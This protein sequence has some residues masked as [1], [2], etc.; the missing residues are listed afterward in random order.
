MSNFTVSDLYYIRA[1][2]YKQVEA[3]SNLDLDDSDPEVQQVESLLDKIE[4][5]LFGEIEQGT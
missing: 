4:Y 3:F 1:M 2:L 5:K